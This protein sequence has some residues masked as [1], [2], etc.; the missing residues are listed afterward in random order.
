MLQGGRAAV[1]AHAEA[2]VKP[3][4]STGASTMLRVVLTAM[5][6]R[7]TSDP[8]SDAS[9]TLARRL[10]LTVAARGLKV[11]L[12]GRR[13]RSL[14]LAPDGTASATFRLVGVDRGPGD[15]TVVIRGDDDETLA[16]LRLTVEVVGSDD[17][18]QTGVARVTANVPPRPILRSAAAPSPRIT[19]AWLGSTA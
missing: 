16:V 2:Q 10:S 13:S 5:P 6:G 18:D 12:G 11:A 9:E 8:A 19:G 7:S 15:V 17:H 1:G 3:I 4:V 14:R